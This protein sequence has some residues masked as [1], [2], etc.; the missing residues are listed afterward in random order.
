MNS[1][2]NGKNLS[3]SGIESIGRKIRLKEGKDV[4][5]LQS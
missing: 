3:T 2:K 5:V 4:W 1:V